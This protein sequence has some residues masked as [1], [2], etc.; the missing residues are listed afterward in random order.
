MAELNTY[1]SVTGYRHV[2][3]IEVAVVRYAAKC[4]QR[5]RVECETRLWRD[6]GHVGV[7]VQ[8]RLYLRVSLHR[9]LCAAQPLSAA[10]P[11]VTLRNSVLADHYWLWMVCGPA[12]EG[13]HD[14]G[15]RALRAGTGIGVA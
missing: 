11:P 14:V 3:G 6:P 13:P 15:E 12:Q 2:P 5:I 8:Q 9:L 10:L 4:G 1:L 7:E